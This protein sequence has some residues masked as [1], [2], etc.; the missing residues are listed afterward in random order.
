MFMAHVEQALRTDCSLP[1]LQLACAKMVSK[2][3]LLLSLLSKRQESEGASAF[4]GQ[5]PIEENISR[6][7]ALEKGKK[8]RGEEKP[9]PVDDT[10]TL[11][12]LLSVLAIISLT[13]TCVLTV[14]QYL[15]GDTAV[16]QA[17]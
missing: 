1:G 2:T 13:L 11:V 4:T 9:E 10:T 14:S 17:L 12:V 6:C 5:C 3:E 8:H 15:V 16:T 7:T